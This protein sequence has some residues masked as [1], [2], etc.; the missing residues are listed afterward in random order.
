MQGNVA[1]TEGKKGNCYNLGNMATSPEN[2]R[3]LKGPEQ[4]QSKKPGKKMMGH[5]APSSTSAQTKQ[6]LPWID[7]AMKAFTVLTAQ[8]KE[9]MA[10]NIGGEK[11]EEDF[12]NA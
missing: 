8:E 3:G 6:D 11:E 10:V 2:A 4:P 9:T 5:K 12:R 1:S 7:A